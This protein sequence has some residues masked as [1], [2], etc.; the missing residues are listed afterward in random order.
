MGYIMH[1]CLRQSAKLDW[2]FLYVRSVRETS[3]FYREKEGRG[4]LGAV[5]PAA[6]A[7]RPEP[8]SPMPPE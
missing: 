3:L 8:P 1:G 6:Y 4:S 5:G 2:N 7:T